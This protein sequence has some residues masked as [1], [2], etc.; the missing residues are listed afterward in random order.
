[1]SS[2]VYF[3]SAQVT[4]WDYSVGEAAGPEGT[5]QKSGQYSELYPLRGAGWTASGVNGIM[6]P[7][8][9]GLVYRRLWSFLV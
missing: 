6:L 7:F 3:A 8:C 5:V 9:Q 2:R 4:R 1:M